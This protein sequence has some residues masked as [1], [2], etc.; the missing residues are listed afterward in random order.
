MAKQLQPDSN[1]KKSLPSCSYEVPF[2]EVQEGLP[3]QPHSN[4]TII[5]RNDESLPGAASISAVNFSR[6][7]SKKHF[8]PTFFRPGF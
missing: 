1:E 5:S 4:R 7:L 8:T 6:L 3:K 2:S